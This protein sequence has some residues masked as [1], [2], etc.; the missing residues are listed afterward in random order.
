MG[1][2]VFVVFVKVKGK[3][4]KLEV[5]EATPEDTASY[6]EYIRHL[7][8]FSPDLENV[9]SLS[10]SNLKLALVPRPVRFYDK[11]NGQIP[12]AQ[13]DYNPRTVPEEALV[14]EPIVPTPIDTIEEH[15]PPIPMSPAEP[16][17]SPEGATT[18]EGGNE[19]E[20]EILA[21]MIAEDKKVNPKM[22]WDQQSRKWREKKT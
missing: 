19:P 4:P 10:L 18:A 7:N 8:R 14:E 12:W 3:P 15:I 9:F 22:V 2:E 11:Y 20:V 1:M 16:E 17:I 13:P 21:K 5:I 6:E